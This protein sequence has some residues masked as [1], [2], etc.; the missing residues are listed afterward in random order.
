MIDS[1]TPHISFDQPV[2]RRP[3]GGRS[4]A[5]PIEISRDLPV[6]TQQV[7][8]VDDECGD[9]LPNMDELFSVARCSADVGAEQGRET[10]GALHQ[11]AVRL[12]S[13][14]PRHTLEPGCQPV[15]HAECLGHR[16][17]AREIVGRLDLAGSAPGCRDGLSYLALGED[18]ERP[19][20]GPRRFPFAAGHCGIEP[21]RR[22]R[23]VT[24]REPGLGFAVSIQCRECLIGCGDAIGQVRSEGEPHVEAVRRYQSAGKSEEAF[25]ASRFSHVGGDAGALKESVAD[26]DERIQQSR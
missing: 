24:G 21:T 5:E 16:G 19:D 3:E 12:E 26:A 6:G 22:L 17:E 20:P 8:T 13:R 4:F 18:R 10:A 7:I 1:A 11:S 15:Q 9:R 14:P 23:C 2:R 25:Q